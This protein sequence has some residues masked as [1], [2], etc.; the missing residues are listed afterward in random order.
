VGVP[1][2]KWGERPLAT[3][4]L[5]EGAQVTVEELRAFLGRAGGSL[6]GAGALGLPL[7]GAE[8]RASASSTR[9]CSGNATREGNLKITT[10]S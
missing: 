1:D 9:R 4:V 7:G 10:E 6:A 8:K 2:E 3:V 5:D